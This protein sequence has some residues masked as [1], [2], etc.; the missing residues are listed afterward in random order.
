L[1]NE[2]RRPLA[3]LEADWQTGADFLEQL[4]LAQE[5]S[6]FVPLPDEASFP[7]E[8]VPGAILSLLIRFSDRDAEFNVHARVLERHVG[9]RVGLTLA[10]LEEERARRE[11]VLTCARGESLPYYRRRHERIPCALPVR[12]ET[13]DGQALETAAISISEGGAQLAMD[14]P[15]PLQE[16]DIVWLHI[17]FPELDDPLRVRGR[18]A[19]VIREGPQPAV[20]IELQYSSVELRD[21]VHDQIRRLRG[22]AG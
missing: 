7:A 20:G 9:E 19:S 10:F 4:D 5:G 15:P 21:R 22:S 11:L 1:T 17:T 13:K 3:A 18:V 14:A 6:F 2:P 12:L 8:A 16:D